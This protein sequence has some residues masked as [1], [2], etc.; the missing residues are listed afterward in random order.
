MI[1]DEFR[2]LLVCPVDKSPLR[3]EPEA[4]VCS[5]CGR[6]YPIENGIP[7]LVVDEDASLPAES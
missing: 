5:S 1:D 6:R 2:G 4:L 7:L 3:D